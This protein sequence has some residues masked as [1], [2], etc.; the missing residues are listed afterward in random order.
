MKPTYQTRTHAHPDD[1]M[2]NFMDYFVTKEN[3]TNRG[4][5]ARARHVSEV[6]TKTFCPRNF[7]RESRF[8]SLALV[9]YLS[10][11][12]VG[13]GGNVRIIH[14][15]KQ[16]RRRRRRIILKRRRV[17]SSCTHDGSAV[18][19]VIRDECA[20]ARARPLAWL[21][22]VCTAACP[23]PLPWLPAV[24]GIVIVLA[25][26]RCRS[27][28]AEIR[29]PPRAA[30]DGRFLC[31]RAS[32]NTASRTRVSSRRTDTHTRRNDVNL[33]PP[34]GLSRSTTSLTHPRFIYPGDNCATATNRI[35]HTYV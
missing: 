12:W 31:S 2:N 35:I 10:V 8:P 32:P 11:G 28:R 22:R 21:L 7:V 24:Y 29:N 30:T 33:L 9:L 17:Y 19:R 34:S 25:E 4:H 23:I 26:R 3:Y 6:K 1:E 27:V 15:N 5:W 13:G 16:Q 20:G 14:N 18:R